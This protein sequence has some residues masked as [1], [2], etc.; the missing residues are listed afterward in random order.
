MS[1]L[2]A[3]I[4]LAAGAGAG[5]LA[6]LFG[7]GG[8][9]IVVPVLI[10]VFQQQ[11][12]DAEVLTHMAVA[13]SLTT[14]VFTS[15]SSVR[16]HH[17]A[18][19]IEW[20]LVMKM[21]I[22]IILGTTAGVVLITEVPGPV[23]QVLIGIFAIL[24]GVKMLLNWQPPGQG[25]L[26]GTP[27]LTGAGGAIGFGSAWFGIGGGTFTVPYLSWMNIPMHRAVAT[28]AACGIPIAL[29][30]AVTNIFSGWQHP[31]LPMGATG[32]VYWPAVLGI[33]LTSVPFAAVGARLAHRLD[34]TLL[35]KAFAVLLCV[36]GVRFI[37]G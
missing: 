13:T 28:S 7:V 29:T 15:L 17:S 35:K 31:Q 11:G 19:A 6:G 9:M 14:I 30:G 36:I 23:L 3:L 34:A 2:L 25:R 10:I 5:L 8:G 12:I 18:G 33:V 4:Y 16:G 26:P 32:F 21:C 24:L 20:S 22:G 1:L 37:W 27:A